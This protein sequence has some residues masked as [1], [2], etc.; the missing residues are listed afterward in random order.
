[1]IKNLSENECAVL[2]VLAVF[3]VLQQS[4]LAAYAA[5]LLPKGERSGVAAAIRALAD[6]KYIREAKDGWALT[7]AITSQDRYTICHGRDLISV[8]GESDDAKHWQAI[9]SNYYW[10]GR[11]HETE[12]IRRRLKAV[13]LAGD[14]D[15]YYLLR[16]E[17]ESKGNAWNAKWTSNIGD[18]W[19]S[20]LQDKTEFPEGIDPRFYPEIFSI[21]AFNA[22]M[23]NQPIAPLI[24]SLYALEPYKDEIPEDTFA[25]FTL[26][27]LY[28]WCGE[29]EPLYDWFNRID[30]EARTPYNI[31]INQS[32][33]ALIVFIQGCLAMLEGNWEI[34]DE[35]FAEIESLLIR[36]YRT[37]FSPYRVI[38]AI[39]LF[40]LVN[41]RHRRSK[42][43]ATFL[44]DTIQQFCLNSC[45][46]RLHPFV[47]LFTACTDSTFVGYE[48]DILLKT[49]APLEAMLY[50]M[51]LY[52]LP[53]TPDTEQR[54]LNCCELAR[55]AADA[56]YDNIALQTYAMI[57][58]HDA[59]R[60]TAAS[61]MEI[62][63]EADKGVA[64]WHVEV[65]KQSWELAIAE[66][67][68]RLDGDAGKTRRTPRAAKR[69]E[70][71]TWW[72]CLDEE[73]NPDGNV[74]IAT[75]IAP[76]L[77]KRTPNGNFKGGRA[78]SLKSLCEDKYDNLLTDHDKAIKYKIV[79]K[80]NIRG[81]ETFELPED[82]LYI[83]A[84]HPYVFR[85][86]EPDSKVGEHIRLEKGEFQ[87]SATKQG[88]DSFVL[89]IPFARAALSVIQPVDATTY[90]IFP[91]TEEMRK[92]RTIAEKYAADGRI[93][94][95]AEGQEQL[96]QLL[97]KASAKY[98]V[99]GHSEALGADNTP[100]V[101]GESDLYMQLVLKQDVLELALRIK[102]FSTE[103]RYVEPGR[104]VEQS[105][106]TVK[107]KQVLLLRSLNEE[108]RVARIFKQNTPDLEPWATG[109]Y[110]WRIDN[111]SDALAILPLLRNTNP[112]LSLV[113]PEG[114]KLNITGIS[115][116]N[117]RLEAQTSM[118]QWLAVSGTVMLDNG[119][120]IQ[121]AELLN[122]ITGRV[123]N[124]VQLSD[125]Q[126]VQLTHAMIKRLEALQLSGTLKGNTLQVSQ[127]AIPM[128]SSCF[129]A[130]DEK[131]W[132]LPTL[133]KRSLMEFQTAAQEKPSLPAQFK[134]TL[135]TY[136]EDG[137][138]W[139]SRLTRCG[140]GACLADDM[141]LGKTIQILAL[142]LERKKDGP[143][144]VVAPASVCHNWEREM[145]RFTPTLRPILIAVNEGNERIEK[146]KAH[147]VLIC[148]YG[149]LISREETIVNKQWNGIILDEAQAIKNHTSKRNKVARRLNGKFRIA[150]TGTPVENRL[151]ELWS[152]FDFLNPGLLGTNQAF[153]AK[154]GD[155]RIPKALKRLVSP[156]L[157]RRLKIDVLEE[158]PPKTEITL[159]IQLADDER[160]AY[161]ACRQNALDLLKE[162]EE[163]TENRILI[164]TQLTR[165]RRFCCHPSLILPDFQGVSAKME[166]LMDLVDELRDNGHRAL[167]FSQFV[168]FLAIVKAQFDKQD[169]SYQYLDGSTPVAD[170]MTYVNEFQEGKGDFFL[171]S[172]KAG[173]TGL[174]LT[175]ANYVILLDPW[176]NPAVESQAADRVHRMGQK[177]P[178]TI[179]RLVAADT[180]EE[181][182]LELHA[183]KKALADDL[184]EGT[185]DATVSAETLMSLFKG[186]AGSVED[187][188]T[189]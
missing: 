36:P 175:A 47:T 115:A 134:G 150:A 16:K 31:F 4:D 143:S 174:N 93:V 187:A 131:E 127:A 102:P 14:T 40:H 27:A 13:V 6:K 74:L 56:G 55:A 5:A 76:R 54:A 180:V 95:P 63:T 182:V 118:E 120:V 29:K 41:L 121:F 169:I 128:L 140:M 17:G 126:F 151:S 38:P 75:H 65:P 113:W 98:R 52:K 32:Q 171:I 166:A 69:S 77:L 189:P 23:A 49:E 8:L 79:R 26:A 186:T 25:P 81:V 57:S 177:Q 10:S 124:F 62:L 21:I 48:K 45:A 139:M 176:W 167:I 19:N 142:L 117:I 90:R 109:E 28:T 91:V 114:E 184:L 173:G 2:S 155:N 66:L 132:A 154:Y 87:I 88:D 12:I 92:L 156:L 135:R 160:H 137:F 11:H 71:M 172:L 61:E 138:M 68:D 51:I 149:L 110:T 147:D 33:G 108:R 152:L 70:I 136:Q 106:T 30:P 179:Y 15:S 46:A 119:K 80:Y 44:L 168:D 125:N 53:R 170:R 42:I 116:P 39:L 105:L 72:I 86:D 141:G 20:I 100:T 111:L 67:E 161:E 59:C 1:M 7:D 94:I 112:P 104:G 130:S 123:G 85:T 83:L 24:E 82:M 96:Q 101:F 60:Q 103:N 158:L 122:K 58:W 188:Q 34:A 3:D 22:M 181:R 35:S 185:G 129:N 9:E 73:K 99:V 164:L 107:N 144:L 37:S 146:A 153:Q 50:A 78:V 18:G 148:S 89:D 162:N 133:L 145:A 84:E 157:L 165:L 97:H 64:L 178:V 163:A 183:T 43:R 159:E